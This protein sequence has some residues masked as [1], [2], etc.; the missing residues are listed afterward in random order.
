MK[1]LQLLQGKRKGRR[2]E[3]RHRRSEVGSQR[4]PLAGS[5]A[6][7]RMEKAAR[8]PVRPS[9]LSLRVEDKRTG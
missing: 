7:R 9:G 2:P 1:S 8:T 4:P 3:V 5:L 6:N